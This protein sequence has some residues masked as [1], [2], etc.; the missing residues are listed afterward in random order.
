MFLAVDKHS[1]R[2][3][4]A[5]AIISINKCAEKVNRNE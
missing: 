1:V 4:D 2:C 3:Q 5:S